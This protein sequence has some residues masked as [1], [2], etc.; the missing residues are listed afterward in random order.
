MMNYLFKKNYFATEKFSLSRNCAKFCQIFFK[1]KEK[2]KEKKAHAAAP[3]PLSILLV[4]RIVGCFW[5]TK[6]SF[7]FLLRKQSPWF[8]F[9][10]LLASQRER[11]REKEKRDRLVWFPSSVAPWISSCRRPTMPFCVSGYKHWRPMW[12]RILCWDVPLVHCSNAA[13]ILSTSRPAKSSCKRLCPSCNVRSLSYFTYLNTSV[14][15]VIMWL[16]GCC[17]GLPFCV[18]KGLKKNTRSF[19]SILALDCIWF[20]IFLYLNFMLQRCEL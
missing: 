7:P 3:A 12:C 1:K 9:P 15:W 19:M 4:D 18:G 20:R 8:C 14:S 10:C 13:S 11:E 2:R 5:T 16:V 6:L 17:S